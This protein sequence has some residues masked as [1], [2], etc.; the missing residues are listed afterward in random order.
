MKLISEEEIAAFKSFLQAHSF[1]FIAGHKEPD[2]DCIFSCLG[3]AELL[4]KTGHQYEL[5]NAGPFKRPEIRR[6]ESLFSTTPTFLSEPER[7]QTGLIM[8]DCSEL[9]RLG[10]LSSEMKGL[11][12]F[13]IDHH[14]TAAVTDTCIIDASAPACACIVQQL[15]EAV[16][17]SLTKEVAQLIF[18][19]MATDTGYFRFLNSDSAEVFRAT[20]RLVDAGVNPREVYDEMTGGKP[21]STRKLLGV[22]LSRAE[23][24]YNNRLVITYETME[25]T[26]KWGQ[27]GRDSDALY[28][29]LLAVDKTEAVVFIRQETEFSCTAGLRSK[30]D[31]DVSAIAAQFGGGGHKNASGLSTDGTIDKLIPAICKE[32]AKILKD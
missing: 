30:N 5:L 22:L 19:G 4:K 31:I 23:R 7:K 2:G 12:T 32:F 9:S 11:D 17:G 13:I 6:R 8:L 15:Y 24:Y 1:F 16:A 3:M 20:A 25:D 14:K 18:F 28:S 10:D 21:Y 26:K 29:L 27:E